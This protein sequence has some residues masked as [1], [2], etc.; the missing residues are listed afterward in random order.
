MQDTSK[1][2]N[3]DPSPLEGKEKTSEIKLPPERQLKLEEALREFLTGKNLNQ[4]R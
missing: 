3:E 2:N 4:K 1:A